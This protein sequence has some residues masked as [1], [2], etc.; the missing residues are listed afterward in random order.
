[1]PIIESGWGHGAP[2]WS[3]TAQAGRGQL[4]WDRS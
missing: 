2:A 3:T 1:M 4:V